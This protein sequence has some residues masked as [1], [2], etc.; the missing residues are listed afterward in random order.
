MRSDP[1]T[2]QLLIDA[3]DDRVVLIDRDRRIVQANGRWIEDLVEHPDA[4]IGLDYHAVF[5]AAALAQSSDVR[6]VTDGLDQV[7]SGAAP[8]FQHEYLGNPPSDRRWF[9]VI[10]KPFE[11]GALVRHIEITRMRRALDRLH[12]A[13]DSFRSLIHDLQVGVLVVGAHGQFEMVNRAACELLGVSE[14]Q[15]AG[16]SPMDPNWQVVRSDDTPCPP[17]AFPDMV[18][19]RT[20]QPV[21]GELLGVKR[22]GS[23]ERRWLVVDA[24]P[25][26]S[27][28][29]AVQRVVTAFFDITALRHAQISRQRRDTQL[30]LAL[31]GASLVAWD[32]RVGAPNV[33][34]SADPSALFGLEPGSFDG[35]WAAY[36]AVI[37]P[38]DRDEVFAANQR[39][40]S[41]GHG[42]FALAHRVVPP[43]GKQRWLE[44]R[45]Q[46]DGHGTE[47]R[48]TGVLVDITAL[49]SAQED[50]DRGHAMLRLALEAAELGLWEWDVITG[51]ITWSDQVERILGLP[52][53]G[54]QGRYETYL[55]SVHPDDRTRV[56]VA[57][58]SALA[59]ET[60]PYQIEHRVTLPAGGVRWIGARG[61]V[62]RND[63]GE[64][65]RMA[66]MVVDLDA[67]RRAERQLDE[68]R[69][70]AQNLLSTMATLVIVLDPQGRVL[71]FNRACERLTGWSEAEV[72]GPAF[73]DLLIPPDERAGVVG[74][75]TSL[76][77]GDFPNSHENHWLT[78]DGRKRLIA[79]NNTCLVA[80]GRIT[81]VIG[82][83]VDITDRHAAE[84]ALHQA[85]AQLERRVEQRTAELRGVV[86]ELETFSYSVSHDLRAPLRAID[87]FALAL[88][89]DHGP[90]LGDEGRRLLGVIRGETSRMGKLIDDLLKL[91]KVGRCELRHE[92]IDVTSECRAIL[93]RLAGR[94]PQRRVSVTVEE[95][96]QA[97]ADPGLLRLV[98]EN[99]LD[100]A[101]KFTAK[102]EPATVAV[103]TD[104]Q[105]IVVTDNG[106]GFDPSF[107]GLLFKPFTRL[108]AS[109]EFPGT[110]IGL[111][112]VARIVERHGG[113]C[114]A[115]G[116]VGRGA[117]IRLRLPT[118][119]NAHIDP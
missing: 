2:R 106:A 39:L 30:L 108:H 92:R 83:G 8:R 22:R 25:Q 90:H 52:P 21:R 66:G 97:N 103:H 49:R 109:G 104:G 112:T 70:F 32:W 23:G 5:G 40:L 43:S 28:D 42:R 51:T 95:G 115:T 85:N 54:S 68:Q 18:A 80:D 77:A 48:M 46:L 78:K 27:G 55:E 111:A 33:E 81:H 35:S 36:L 62:T 72:V 96:I 34:W 19:L 119:S 57:I 118:S 29:G 86:Q 9:R 6:T 61:R 63:R 58:A 114:T 69:R 75:F 50:A 38:D 76:T 24:S 100:N 41:A 37:H 93:V 71:Q 31:E 56:E 16:K 53:G 82:T 87:G 84:V 116:A 10:I 4:G 79:W 88:A 105:G 99:L 12:Q 13:D 117:T 14:E 107:A 20:G 89:E 17:E 113:T 110:G 1:R 64:P 98:L 94:D 3:L 65:V 15:F 67:R 7:L 74:V 73:W 11:D 102:T 26:V 59:G 44:V 47:Q 60:D 101:W 45:C 91:A